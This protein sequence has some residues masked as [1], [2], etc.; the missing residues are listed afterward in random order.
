M[1]TGAIAPSR[2]GEIVIVA[3]VAGALALAADRV[4][5]WPRAIVLPAAVAV[6]ACLVDLALG[7][8]LTQRSLLGP[9]PILGAR[10]FGIGNE[11][12][13]VIG[14]VALLGIG[15]AVATASA[16]VQRRAFVIVGGALAFALSWG[17]LGADV[18]AA[19]MLAA[20]IAAAWVAV[21][22]ALAGRRRIAIVLAAPVVGIA[23]L[24]LVDLATG[25]DA[26][27]TRSVLRAG[28]LGELA[29]VA[30]RRLELSYRSLGRGII[31]LL[32][33]IAAVA[34]VWGVRKRR[35]VLARLGDVP[36]LE[37]GA[38]GAF[39]AVVVGALTNDSGPVVLLIGT[40]YLALAVGYFRNAPNKWV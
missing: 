4:L 8:A 13:V 32:S 9:N 30:Q 11:L 40:I 24:A 5:P 34:L 22:G 15:A 6:V 19:I 1:L 10:F 38:W 2:L 3:L 23:A 17:R 25:G 33:V 37:A 14:V 20:G 28:G 27:F 29:D 39:V 31:G 7:S 35:W 16:R 18:G 26:H 21:D 12:E 36:G